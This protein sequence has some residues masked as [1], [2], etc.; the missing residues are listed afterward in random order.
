MIKR[1]IEFIDENLNYTKSDMGDVELE[2]RWFFYEEEDDIIYG[3]DDKPINQKTP[4]YFNPKSCEVYINGEK[5]QYDINNPTLLIS[6]ELKTNEIKLYNGDDVFTY[7]EELGCDLDVD[8]QSPVGKEKLQKKF[9]NI[10]DK[11]RLLFLY[12][13]RLISST[14]D[15]IEEN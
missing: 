6:Y 1:F 14:F 12:G 15:I 10:D 5:S 4:L 8:I 3:C 11:Y 9:D 7:L 13:N 2:D